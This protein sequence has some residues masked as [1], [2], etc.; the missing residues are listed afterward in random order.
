L[1]RSKIITSFLF[2]GEEDMT[3]NADNE[4]VIRLRNKL[5]IFKNI[6]LKDFRTA[7]WTN[8]YAVYSPKVYERTYSLLNAVSVSEVKQEGNTL[9]FDVYIDINKLNHTSVVSGHNYYNGKAIYSPALLDEG[10]RQEGYE[11]EDFFHNYPARNFMKK[12]LEFIEND[13]KKSLVNI[14]IL[15]IKKLGGKHKY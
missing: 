1:K 5:E 6:A 7:L 3:T 11:D 4:L 14:V 13:L 10:H 12:A 15:E 9:Y 2:W 8:V